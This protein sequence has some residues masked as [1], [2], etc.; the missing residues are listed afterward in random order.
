MMKIPDTPASVQTT[1]TKYLGIQADRMRQMSE[2]LKRKR[3]KF[4]S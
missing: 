2:H 4:L 1:R 3:I